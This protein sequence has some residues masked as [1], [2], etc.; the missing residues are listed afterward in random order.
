MEKGYKYKNKKT[1]PFDAIVAASNEIGHLPPH[2]PEVEEAV[3][4]AIVNAIVAGDLKINNEKS[5]HSA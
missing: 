2:A 4:G 1:G 3:I 5:N